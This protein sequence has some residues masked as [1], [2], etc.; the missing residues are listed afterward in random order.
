M[1]NRIAAVVALSLAIVAFGLSGPVQA[2][3]LTGQISGLVT[4]SGGG[5]LPGATVTVKNTGTNATR[6]TVTG[7]DGAFVFPDLFAGKYDLTVTVSG[8]KT[9]EQKGIDLGST[10]RLGLRT[11]AL[12][13]RR[14]LGNRD[15]PVRSRAGSDHEWRA[16]R[17]DHAR[18]HRRHRPQGPRLRRHAQAAAGGHR[19]EKP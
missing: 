19:H 11:I 9:Y 4:D 10:E 16:F 5:V 6:E 18:E 13:S 3:G 17:V 12:E 1:L 15:R 14:P 7:A 2:Q 8:F